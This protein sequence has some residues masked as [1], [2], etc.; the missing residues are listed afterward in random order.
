MGRLLFLITTP[1]WLPVLAIALFVSWRREGY[2]IR[3][4]IKRTIF[5]G[6]S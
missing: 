3:E 6:Y 1:L 4:S 5:G 2:G